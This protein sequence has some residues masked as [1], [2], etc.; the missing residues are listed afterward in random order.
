MIVVSKMLGHSKPS[1]TLDIY[2]HLMNEM[3]GEAPR[4]MDGLVTPV[5]LEMGVGSSQESPEA[6]MLTNSS[7]KELH[8][9]AP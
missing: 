2:G 9:T 8:Q 4:I 7:P 6:A 1:I 5:K 3:Q